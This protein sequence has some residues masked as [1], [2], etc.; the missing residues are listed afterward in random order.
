M[1][2]PSI[3]ILNIFSR[4]IPVLIPLV[5]LLTGIRLLL[6]PAF[7]RLEYS[8]PNFPDDTY[9]DSEDWL[10]LEERLKWAPI[11]LEYLLIDDDISF[12]GDLKFDDGNPLYDQR[13]LE[14]M[15]DVKELVNLVLWIWYANLALFLFFVLWARRASWWLEF[16]NMLAVGGK[17]TATLIGALILLTIVSFDFIFTGFHRIFFEGDSWRFRFSDTLLRLFPERFW[18]DTFIFLGG[19]SLIVGI[20]LWYFL[21]RKVSQDEE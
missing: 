4:I 14:H 10:S 15:V 9:G 21:S 17:L 8:M 13:Q 20:C 1:K 6:S 5:I 19:F 12:L 18:L 11:A 7:I 3:K 2:T 16:R